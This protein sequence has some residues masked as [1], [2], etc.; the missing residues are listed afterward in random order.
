MQ[1]KYVETFAG[2]PTGCV[3]TSVFAP[4]RE[5]Q[6]MGR[7]MWHV[8][9]NGSVKQ[10]SEEKLRKKL[11]SGAF[12]GRQLARRAGEEEW[13]PLYESELFQQEVA[14]TGSPREAAWRRSS[15]HA[16]TALF[17]GLSAF[18]VPLGMVSI[19]IFVE[20]FGPRPGLGPSAWWLLLWPFVISLHLS[21]LSLIRQYFADQGSAGQ[22]VLSPAT[23]ESGLSG[24]FL[25]EVNAALSKSALEVGVQSELRTAAAELCGKIGELDEVV[26]SDTIESL[27]EQED[28]CRSKAMDSE[29][30]QLRETFLDEATAIGQRCQNLERTATLLTRLKAQQR[31]FL[32]QLE[33]LTL[34]A[35][36][37]ESKAEVPDLDENLRTLRH[38]LRADDEV[39]EALARARLASKQRVI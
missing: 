4:L 37:A 25:E 9:T 20:Y 19:V 26:S 31:T 33:S 15:N 34:G 14:F 18:Y 24:S 5:F 6:V 21:F 10:L 16:E 13:A 38:Q 39:D 12:S 28:A 35:L 27:R 30:P 3:D 1:C 17:L 22:A 7:P 11:R 29:D 2:W 23:V 8:D 36:Q 32:H